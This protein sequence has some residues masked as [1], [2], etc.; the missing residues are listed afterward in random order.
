MWRNVRIAALNTTLQL[1]V[2][3]RLERIQKLSIFR[4]GL[5][6]LL[7]CVGNNIHLNPC[8]RQKGAKVKELPE[9]I[10]FQTLKHTK[11]D[12]LEGF[13][14]LLCVCVCVCRSS[15]DRLRIIFSVSWTENYGCNFSLILNGKIYIHTCSLFFFFFEKTQMF[16][17]NLRVSSS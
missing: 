15:I 7:C 9:D 1:L 16:L 4:S 14:L 6:F 8:K 5:G 11:A 3:Y 17:V 13:S 2:I 12:V 10:L